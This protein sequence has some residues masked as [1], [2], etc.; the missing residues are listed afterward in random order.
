MEVNVGGHDILRHGHYY[1]ASLVH[2][3][4]DELVHILIFNG[5]EKVGEINGANLPVKIKF[6][7]STTQV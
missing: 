6:G 3:H 2:L 7:I 5:L 1:Q 4:R